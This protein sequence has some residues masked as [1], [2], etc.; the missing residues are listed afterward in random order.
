MKWLMDLTTQKLL[1]IVFI[2]IVLLLI[3]NPPVAER[4]WV[5]VKEMTASVMN[6]LNPGE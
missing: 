2:V 4:A 3:F 1:L 6:V 5:M